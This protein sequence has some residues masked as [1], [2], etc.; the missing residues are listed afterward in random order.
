MNN[1]Y[2]YCAFDVFCTVNNMYG[3]RKVIQI[4]YMAN[5]VQRV[6]YIKISRLVLE[7]LC[8]L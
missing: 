3:R 7:L 2:T 4:F 6:Q 1:Y 8:V 5:A